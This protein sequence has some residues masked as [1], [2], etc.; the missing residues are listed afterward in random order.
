M[1]KDVESA[2]KK[3]SPDKLQYYTYCNVD[4]AYGIIFDVPAG[5]ATKHS[6][7]KVIPA[8]T[9]INKKI[10]GFECK[11]Y[12]ITDA[13]NDTTYILVTDKLPSSA[14]YISYKLFPYCILAIRKNYIEIFPESLETHSDISEA[15]FKVHQ[16]PITEIN[17]T[18][19]DWALGKKGSISKDSLFPAFFA[20]DIGGKTFTN[21]DFK[22]RDL[23][24]IVFWDKFLFSEGMNE[25]QSAMIRAYE[26][27][28]TLMFR[29]LDSLSGNDQNLLVIAPTSEY[30]ENLKNNYSFIQSLS[31][32]HIVPNSEAWQAMLG[33]SATPL[34]V[35]VAKNGKIIEVISG[36]DFDD[37]NY[38]FFFK[39]KLARFKN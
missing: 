16:L 21:E 36:F 31:K 26:K 38:Y 12:C 6:F 28:V 39:Q 19:E 27:S 5:I 9:G 32:L 14:G 1:Q 3:V 18:N 7:R 33:I 25:K 29:D 35:V 4:K 37:D 23:S 20:R 24:L 8:P 22:K 11:E 15:D 30:L 2:G 34:I 17:S 13:I 10:L